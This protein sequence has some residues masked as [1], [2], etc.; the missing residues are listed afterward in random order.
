MAVYK[1]GQTYWYTFVWNGRRVQR[2]TKQGNRKAAIDIE[3]AYRTAL[4][5]GEVG[6][7]PPK[8]E[9]R[10]IAELLD[11]LKADYERDAKSSPQNRSLLA[12][13]RQDFGSKMATELTAVD[14]EKY[15]QRRKNE[16]SKNA[17]INR[18]TEI[19]RRC[20][21]LAK[22]TPPDMVRLSEKNNTRQ[23]F[24][25]EAEF[26]VLHSHLPNDLKDFCRFAYLTGW[27]RNEIRS[28]RWSDIEG[29]I[30]RL[31]GENAKNRTARYVV[32]AGEL[33]SILERRQQERLVEGVLTSLVFHRA[34]ES[35]GEIKKSWATAC[36]AAGLGAM[37]C[38][39]C[40]EPGQM[41][42]QT[43]CPNC[44]KQR[45]Y[46]GKIFHDFRRTAA[47]NLIR[48]G[49]GERTCMEILGHKT[50]S[51]FDRYNIT[52]EKDLA[53]AMER[54]EQF[55]QAAPEKVVAIGANVS[56]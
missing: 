49:V 30:V 33:K 25:S 1:R 9:R 53:E 11:S 37:T 13:A 46:T 29:N 21:K 45:T 27:R 50:R 42:Q 14:V 56:R 39:K 5:K 48:A 43:R 17:T 52:S 31:R 55:H 54:L 40:G 28:L 35:V 38:P 12:R 10:T 44:K 51:M 34:G 6:L 16:G 36:V 26:R 3:S 2:S 24:F 7:A 22:L 8:R 47:R 19:L 4:A 18:V 32:L 41:G 23:G 20:Y 15:V